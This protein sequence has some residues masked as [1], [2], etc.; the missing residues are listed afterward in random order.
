MS[1]GSTFLDS[2]VR[3]GFAPPLLV[4]AGL[5]AQR[6]GTGRFRDYFW[7]RIVYPITNP[8]GETIGL[9]ARAMGD[10]QPKYLNSPETP[11]FT[12]GRVLYGLY[13]GLAE[14]RKKR[15]V[16]LLEGYM[17]VLAA[18]QFGMT[19]ASAPLGTAVTPDHAALIKRYAEEVVFV[20]DPDNA[21]ASAALR[22]AEILLEQGLAVRI[23]TVPDELDP[24][25]FLHRDGLAA[26]E[27]C[28]AKAQDLPDFKTDRALA[29]FPGRLAA[30]DKAKVAAEVLETIAKTPDEVLKREWMRQLA[31]RLGVDEDALRVQ[32]GKASPPY[33][34]PQP[35]GQAPSVKEAPAR[36]PRTEEAMLQALLQTPALCADLGRVTED[37]FAHA[38]ARRI[39]LALREAARAGRAEG[40]AW[41][42][43]LLAALTPDD[44][45]VAAAL[46]VAGTGPADPAA[47]LEQT[48]Q[49]T[50]LLRRYRDLRAVLDARVQEGAPLDASMTAE[51]NKLL[52]RLSDLRLLDRLKA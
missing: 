17:D 12:K 40:P 47:Q 14:V 29:R 33:P 25:E 23:A 52:K 22:G 38:G 15:R 35:R 16:V 48:V 7:G 26:L 50:R 49:E 31:Q 18:H 9:G 20:F 19:I 27:A 21:G 45:P 41:S 36:L 5:A 34:R 11:L 4:K 6:E 24:D 43:D 30:T 13:E 42:A 44:A 51:Y 28:L 37:D 32:L 46:L 1:N 2:A 8:R 10:A 3:K 39:F